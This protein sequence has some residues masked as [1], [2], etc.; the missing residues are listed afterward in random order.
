[1]VI[2]KRAIKSLGE[3]ALRVADLDQ[4]QSFY[5]NV[6]GLNLMQRFPTSAFFRIAEGVGGHTQVFALFD[7]SSEGGSEPDAETTT[8]DHI[9]FSVLLEDFYA[10][11]NRVEQLG[12]PTRTAE[13]EWVHWRSFYVNDPEGNV[14]EWVCYDPDV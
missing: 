10:E 14:V 1:M 13:H 6:V 11:K 8:V 3:I 4:M 5:E 9:A 2:E 12:I 7:R